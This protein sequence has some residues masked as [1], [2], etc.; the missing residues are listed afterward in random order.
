MSRHV[1]QWALTQRGEHSGAVVRGPGGVLELSQRSVA[2]ETLGESGCSLGAKAVSRDPA[3]M[4]AEAGAEACQRALTQKR[5]LYGAAA[6]FSSLSTPF[7]L[8]QLAIMMAEATPS[9]LRERSI[10]SVGFVP[11]SSS[12]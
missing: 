2:L 4:G 7:L 12:I 8:M 5:T 11:L 9:P 1:C 3:S 10:F 6:H